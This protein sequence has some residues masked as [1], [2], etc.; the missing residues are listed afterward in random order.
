MVRFVVV[1]YLAIQVN[2]NDLRFYFGVGDSLIWPIERQWMNLQSGGECLIKKLR[3]LL[4]VT[5]NFHWYIL[6]SSM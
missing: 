1:V 4:N 6:S 2:F 3:K 5:Q